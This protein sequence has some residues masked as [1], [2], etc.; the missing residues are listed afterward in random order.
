[1]AVELTYRFDALRAK[2]TTYTYSTIAL[3]G[4]FRLPAEA[5]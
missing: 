1:V 2:G 5:P 3:G 4:R